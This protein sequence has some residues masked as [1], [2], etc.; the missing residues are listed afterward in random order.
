[1]RI[2]VLAALVAGLGLVSLP[3]CENREGDRTGQKRD[4][5][6]DSG[7]PVALEATDQSFVTTAARANLAEIEAGRIATERSGNAEVKKFA[8]RMIDD[9]GKANADLSALARKKGWSVPE[10]PDDDHHRM[11]ADLAELSG[12]DFDR[13][14]VGMMVKDHV[15]AVAL[16]EEQA[17]L[18]KDP[19]LSSFAEKTAPVLQTHL[20]K[21][22][23]LA[24]KVG[25]P[26]SAD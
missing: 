22:R 20:K 14:Y 25:A 7:A 26:P 8:Q 18:G 16:F 19:D 21:A 6:K 17:K 4:Q 15:K 23:D 24:G 12:A 5:K 10:Q 11:A 1:M 2:Q 13:K 3:G 9:H